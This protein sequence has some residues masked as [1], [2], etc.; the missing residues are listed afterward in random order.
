MAEDLDPEIGEA[1]ARLL[2]GEPAAPPP[3][4]SRGR[5]T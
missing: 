2:D 4:A 5:P 3:T 1:G